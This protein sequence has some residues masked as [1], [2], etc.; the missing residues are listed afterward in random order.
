MDRLTKH[1]VLIYIGLGLY[2]DFTETFELLTNFQ[3]L[4]IL[5]QAF[6]RTEGEVGGPGFCWGGFDV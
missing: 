5:Y 4:R 2:Q 6:M 3:I 1:K